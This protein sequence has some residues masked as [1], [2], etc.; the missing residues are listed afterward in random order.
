[1]R[2]RGRQDG[3]TW[4]GRCAS[5]AIVRTVVGVPVGL[6]LGVLVLG[7]L[8]APVPERLTAAR[9]RKVMFQNLNTGAGAAVAITTGLFVSGPSSGAVTG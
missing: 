3:I 5:A 1:M 2:G 4:P 7:V 9:G 6:V 8:V